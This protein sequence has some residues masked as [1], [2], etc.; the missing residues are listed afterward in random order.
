MGSSASSRTRRIAASAGDLTLSQ[1]QQREAGLGLA[2]ELVAL[3]VRA[4][5]CFELAADAVQLGALVERG[6]ERRLAREPLARAD[7]FLS[8]RATP[9]AAA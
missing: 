8:R 7:R 5:C 9:R 1:A 4:F 6:A 2:A 3:S